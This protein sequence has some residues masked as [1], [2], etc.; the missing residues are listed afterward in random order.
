[1]LELL[2]QPRHVTP[3]LSRPMKPSLKHDAGLPQMTMPM[4]KKNVDTKKRLAAPHKIQKFSH[5]V[6]SQSSHQAYPLPGGLGD[7]VK[8]VIEG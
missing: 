4:K 7:V 1:M 5:P 6:S 3:S 2:K 8:H